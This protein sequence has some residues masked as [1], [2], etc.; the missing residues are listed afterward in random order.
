MDIQ[1]T[2]P[3][4]D[5]PSRRGFLAL[6]AAAGAG[7][8]LGILPTFTASAA[9][10]RPTESPMLSAAAAAKNELWWQA[11]GSP[12]SMIEQGLPVG[13]GRLGALASN[14]PS[15]EHLV[16]SDATL[17]TGGLNDKLESDGQFPYG[18][19]DFGSLTL[20][21][22]LTVAIPDHDLGNVNNYRRSLDMA[23]GLISTSYEING[24]T[25]RRQVFASRPDDAIVLYFSQQGGGSY[26]GSVSSPA[27]TASPRSPTARDGTP[28]SAP[29]SPTA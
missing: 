26:T 24:V 6:A 7:T 25:Y 12:N 10:L 23:Q 21:A 28:R 9:P 29:P 20:L 11:P 2:E 27:P 15:S 3:S 16:I 17:W 5:A 22:K 8:A 19:A 18:R 4:D 13:N 1:H 14:D